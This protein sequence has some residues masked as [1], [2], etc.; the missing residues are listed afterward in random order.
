MTANATMGKPFLELSMVAFAVNV[1]AVAGALVMGL[2]RLSRG[3]HWIIVV[4][5]SIHSNPLYRDHP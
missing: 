3:P 2:L 1:A 4:T 5:P